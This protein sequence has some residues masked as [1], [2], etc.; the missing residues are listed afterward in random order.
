MPDLLQELSG[1]LVV[2]C[3]ADPGSPLA[4]PVHLSAMAASVV[5]GGASAI[6][7]E[8][9]ANIQAIKDRVRVPVIGL[10][11]ALRTNTEVYI[12][13]SIDD[14]H[15]IA[16]AGADIIAFD[17]TDRPRPANVADLVRAVHEQG[18]L[19]MA[20]IS[21]VDEARSALASGAD[22]VSTTMAGYTSYSRGDA[23]P[24]FGLMQALQRAGLPF[25]AEGRVWTIEEALRC[26]DLGANFIVVGS[27]ITRP[28][29]ITQ[30]FT[31][32]I[33]ARGGA[34]GQRKALS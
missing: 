26:F 8:G 5:A 29:M 4:E 16:A 6:R 30:R 10:V 25:V 31:Q 11:K 20:D 33:A 23:G 12:T 34:P 18:R 7:T 9:I 32:G 3:Q 13:P 22:V 15:H 19:A 24:D 28:T 21:T 14:V 2:S 17:A 1:T 27:A